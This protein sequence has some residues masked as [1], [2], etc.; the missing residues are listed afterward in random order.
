MKDALS[1]E[2]R[3]AIVRMHHAF[4][5]KSLRETIM[6][7]YV[8]AVSQKHRIHSAHRL[9]PFDELRGEARRIYQD[10]AAFSLRPDDQVTP[11]AKA[12]FRSEATEINVVGNVRGKGVDAN[13]RIVMFD[14]SDRSSWTSDQR[15]QSPFRFIFGGGLMMNDR[16]IAGVDKCFRSNLPARVTVDTRRVDEE[17]S[18]NIF[19]QS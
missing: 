13:A 3:G 5:V 6:I 15:H 4:T 14:S 10:V 16:N 19:G 11:G 8:V 17:I 12:C 2:P 1:P 9:D 18:G 7:R